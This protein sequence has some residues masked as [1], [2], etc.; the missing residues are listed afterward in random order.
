MAPIEGRCASIVHQ[1]FDTK[2][3]VARFNYCNITRLSP[4][5]K[6]VPSTVGI[7]GNERADQKSEQETKSFQLEV[8]LTLK[9]SK[10]IISIFIDKYTT[11]SQKNKNLG[12]PWE[13]LDT[14][15]PIPRHLDRAKAVV[16]FRLT[17]G[18]DLWRVN[19]HWLGLAADKSCPV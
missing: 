3:P 5:V 15:S 18:H 6:W 1:P 16:H 7:P 13:T 8:S 2:P 4:V 19:L 17:S 9:R 12:K 10:S 11:V 14:F